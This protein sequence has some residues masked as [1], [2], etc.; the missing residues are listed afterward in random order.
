V[1]SEALIETLEPSTI[2]VLLQNEGAKLSQAGV[3]AA[4]AASRFHQAYIPLLLRRPELKPS[5]AYVIFWWSDPDSRRLI[6]TRFAV[7]REV[8]QETAGDVFGLAA[9]ENWQDPL[10][11]KAL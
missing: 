9:S 8:L 4:V 6:L 2:E 1:V 3:E 7:S 11:R 5:H 10:V